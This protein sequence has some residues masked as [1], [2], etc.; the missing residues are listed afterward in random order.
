MI[1]A[2]GVI[3]TFIVVEETEAKRGD[4]VLPEPVDGAEWILKTKSRNQALR[5]DYQR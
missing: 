1:S 5:L 3:A 2:D 4:T